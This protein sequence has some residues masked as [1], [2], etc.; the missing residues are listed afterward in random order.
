MLSTRNQLAFGLMGHWEL[1]AIA[2]VRG[3]TVGETRDGAWKKGMEGVKREKGDEAD[4]P[5]PAAPYPP[6]LR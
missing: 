2:N 6:P 5:S 3:R 1:M 4:R